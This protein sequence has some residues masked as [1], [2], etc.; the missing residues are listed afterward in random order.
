MF[1]AAAKLAGAE[2]TAATAAKAE[3]SKGQQDSSS[4]SNMIQCCNSANGSRRA[5][6]WRYLLC[7]LTTH[8]RQLYPEGF[9]RMPGSSA[10]LVLQPLQLAGMCVPR[11]YHTIMRH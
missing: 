11:N 4:S 7:R 8:L 6:N 5:C 2:F 1:I 3:A 9:Y 10:R